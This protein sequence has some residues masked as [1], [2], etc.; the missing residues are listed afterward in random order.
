MSRT[1]M[2]IKT[3]FEPMKTDYLQDRTTLLRPMA[4][5]FIEN[6]RTNLQILHDFFKRLANSNDE[7]ND[8]IDDID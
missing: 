8:G 2:N 5:N 3:G 1:Y 4:L 7:N 6:I